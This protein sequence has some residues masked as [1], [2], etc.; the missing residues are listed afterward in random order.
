MDL[1]TALGNVER[2]DRVRGEYILQNWRQFFFIFFVHLSSQFAPGWSNILQIDRAS[3]LRHIT[4]LQRTYPYATFVF[5]IVKSLKMS[6]L[7]EC[8]IMFKVYRYFN[9][10]FPRIFPYTML[11]MR[12]VGS[13]P[14]RMRIIS[15]G[16]L[17]SGSTS[18]FF[19][20]S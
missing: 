8:C 18:T 1:K 7:D 12:G 9:P 14:K 20:V 16:F 2:H 17:C 4:I 19:L 6:R 11:P 13:S 3:F 5:F 10:P 15:Y